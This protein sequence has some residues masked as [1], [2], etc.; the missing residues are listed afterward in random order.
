MRQSRRP[1]H[2]RVAMIRVA[3]R[4]PVDE[5][6]MHILANVLFDAMFDADLERA[7]QQS[8]EDAPVARPHML[9]VEEVETIAPREG[10][11]KAFI[12]A[13]DNNQCPICFR[14][15]KTNLHVRRTPCGHVFCSGCLTRWVCKSSASCPVCRLQLTSSNPLP[16]D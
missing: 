6:A 7:A 14:V 8:L 5:N 3:S 15:F 10:F 2:P 9:T 4:A 1:R 13:N 12:R 11:R 16:A